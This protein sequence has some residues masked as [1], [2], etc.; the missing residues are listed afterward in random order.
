MPIPF[1][2]NEET[3]ISTAIGAIVNAGELAGSATLVWRAG[4]VTHAAG[5]GWR[6][7][8][9][10]LPIERDTLFRIASM[11]KPITSA[12]ALILFEEGRFA[13]NDPIARLLGQIAA[14]APTSRNARAPRDG[15]E[16]SISSRKTSTSRYSKTDS[17]RRPRNLKRNIVREQE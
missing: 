8:E 15:E 6:D 4:K 10:E 12:A 16:R 2:L 5:V 11:T 17:V 1:Q 13:L 9:A 7:V 14:C 3:P